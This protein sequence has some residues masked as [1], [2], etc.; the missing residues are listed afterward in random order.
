MQDQ[1]VIYNTLDI[2][3][4][5]NDPLT[6][7]A[8]FAYTTGSYLYVGSPAPFN[9]LW[10]E[11]VAGALNAVTVVPSVSI[12]FGNTWVSAVDLIDTTNGMTGSG[13]LSWNTDRL[14]GWDVEQTS[15]D[16][17]GI[18]SF[19]IYWKYWLRLSFDQNFTAGTQLQ[20]IGQNF[21]T[22]QDL[23]AIYPDLNNTSLLDSFESGKTNWKLQHF[24]AAEEIVRELRAKNIIKNRSEI[25][26]WE[27]LKMASIHKVAEIAYR[28]FGR[29]YFDQLKQ[30]SLDY[31]SAVNVKFYDLD[32]SGNGSLE[33]EERHTSTGFGRR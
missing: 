1:R 17:S 11:F 28:G 8:N 13:R 26:N 31:K 32:K 29:P 6:P 4:K 5:V 22:D 23:F 12:W 7:A 33:P 9:N 2:S 27:L 24:V 16:V 19:K 14:K 3:A 15:E 25:L 21:S 10:F 18:T 30:A 20:Y